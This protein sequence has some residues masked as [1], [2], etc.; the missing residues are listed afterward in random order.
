MVVICITNKLL[1]MIK[2]CHILCNKG[3]HSN[4]YYEDIINDYSWF[5]F[6]DLEYIKHY[7][8]GYIDWLSLE[9]ESP[10]LL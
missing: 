1:N 2:D 7:V 10:I 6:A 4:E 9:G 5:T 8:Q 3:A